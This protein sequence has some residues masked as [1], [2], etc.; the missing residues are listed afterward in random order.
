MS[1]RIVLKGK[2]E[3]LKPVIMQILATHQLLQES[4]LAVVYGIPVTTFQDRWTFPPQVKLVFYQS[5]SEVQAPKKPVY[6]EITYR[7]I[8]E[9]SATMTEQK[10]IAVANKIKQKFIT[11][12][13]FVWNKGKLIVRYEDQSKGYDFNLFVKS[14]QDGRSIIEQVLDLNGHSPDWEHLRVSTSYD[15]YPDTP[16]N[17]LVY[18]KQRRRPRRRPVESVKF[19]YAE[20]HLWGLPNAITLVDSTGRRPTPLISSF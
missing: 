16:P 1:N 7:L 9:T 15:N 3:L 11:G 4:D 6:G 14:E 10:A 19:R 20:L 13:Q 8:N 12:T 17:D 2:S 18:E 5:N